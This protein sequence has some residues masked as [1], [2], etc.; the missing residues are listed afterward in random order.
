[1]AELFD[2]V[3]LALSKFPAAA[4]S[5]QAAL[6]VLHAF[7]FHVLPRQSGAERSRNSMLV[8]RGL[9]RIVYAVPVT[10]GPEPQTTTLAAAVL[11]QLL[12]VTVRLQA[13]LA[14][15]A[16]ARALAVRV[17]RRV[18]QLVVAVILAAPDTGSV[19]VAPEA[20][21]ACLRVGSADVGAGLTALTAAAAAVRLKT[22]R[23]QLASVCGKPVSPDGVPLAAWRALHSMAITEGTD[24]SELTLRGL[25][26]DGCN[27][28]LTAEPFSVTQVSE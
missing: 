13:G 7:C 5:V 23:N 22:V 15:D 11:L 26:V 21:A 12:R 19:P 17:Q 10:M 8:T 1:M 9:G 24:A 27:A 28:L 6:A 2:S 14:E 3:A 4:D 16:R 25:L 20:A 18:L